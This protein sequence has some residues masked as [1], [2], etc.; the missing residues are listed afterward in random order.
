MKFRSSMKKKPIT[1]E[2]R[3]SRNLTLRDDDISILE[4]E[5]E[6]ESEA[7]LPNSLTFNYNLAP[8]SILVIK[9]L[10]D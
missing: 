9:I 5:A 8:V 4:D 7:N 2:R 3:G 10:I 1:L 6:R